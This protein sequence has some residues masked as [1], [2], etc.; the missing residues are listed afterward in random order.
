M[1]VVLRAIIP[2]LSTTH[3]TAEP[4]RR[5]SQ[6]RKGRSRLDMAHSSRPTT[7][8]LNEKVIIEHWIGGHRASGVGPNLIYDDDDYD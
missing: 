5:E 6:D 4:T 2:G 1:I 7:R 8:E 3:P